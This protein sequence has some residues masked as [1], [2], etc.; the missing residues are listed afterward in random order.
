MSLRKFF[1]SNRSTPHGYSFERV[2]VEP[3]SIRHL[4]PDYLAVVANARLLHKQ[5]S[6]LG[7]GWPINITLE[8]NLIDL[9]WHQKEN[10][11]C[12]SFA[13][14]IFC[15]DAPLCYGCIYINGRASAANLSYWLRGDIELPFT[16]AVFLET[17]HEWISREWGECQ[18]E[19]ENREKQ[20]AE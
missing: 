7:N 15:V 1:D 4:L 9:A 3:L 2:V 17:L 16:E 10:A 19:V 5:Y 12:N 6:H 18:I 8:D 13:Y 11:D 14:T 20:C